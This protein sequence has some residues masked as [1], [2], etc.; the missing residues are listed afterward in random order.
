VRIDVHVESEIVAPID[1]EALRRVLINLLDNAVKYGPAVQR[2]TV[3]LG[4]EQCSA[5]F[6]VDDEG[7][8]IPVHEREQV[9]E[10]FRGGERATG[11][12]RRR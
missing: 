2:I 7:P 1:R 8:G 10:P 4:L 3:T 5:V 9:R 12:G 6:L 11:P